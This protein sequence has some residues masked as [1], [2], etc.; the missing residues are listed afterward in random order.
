VL[1]EAVPKLAVLE[2]PLIFGIILATPVASNKLDRI[3][4]YVAIR[5]GEN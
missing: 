5:D 2:Q 4:K 1:L 3:G